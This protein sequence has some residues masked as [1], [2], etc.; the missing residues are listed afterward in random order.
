MKISDGTTEIELFPT[1]YDMAVE[2]FTELQ[3]SS[4]GNII[5]A[6]APGGMPPRPLR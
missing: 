5:A 2:D 6:A 1:S 4:S 3:Y